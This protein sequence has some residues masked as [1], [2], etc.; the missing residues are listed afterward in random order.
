M[1]HH[2]ALVL[3]VL[4]S[5]FLL[6]HHKAFHC[7]SLKSLWCEGGS[8]ETFE[9]NKNQIPLC[10]RFLSALTD[11]FQTWRYLDP[12]YGNPVSCFPLLHTIHT[13]QHQAFIPSKH[14]LLYPKFK[15]TKVEFSLRPS[16]KAWQ[17]K[18]GPRVQLLNW[19]NP[20]SFL[21]VFS[22]CDVNDGLATLN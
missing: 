8:L 15:F 1:M 14:I 20:E 16:A 5:F 18:S 2:D 10:I 17:E 21:K 12:S 4:H 7:R 13:K 6:F 19:S 11:F 22:H 9:T 3:S